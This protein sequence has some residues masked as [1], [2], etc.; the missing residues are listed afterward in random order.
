M[1]VNVRGNHFNTKNKEGKCV[2][3]AKQMGS[4]GIVP[5]ILNLGSSIRSIFLHIMQHIF[6]SLPGLKYKLLD[7]TNMAKQSLRPPSCQLVHGAQS[8]TRW[9][10]S[11]KF[12][13]YLSDPRQCVYISVF[14]TA[15]PRSVT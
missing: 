7:S 8:L 10:Q 5:R 11:L 13:Q 15:L 9:R 3:T 4:G 2:I 1:E 14:R 12:S 6:L